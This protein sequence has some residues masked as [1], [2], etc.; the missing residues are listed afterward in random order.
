MAGS[1]RAYDGACS[2]VAVEHAVWDSH[3]AC[4]VAG[5]GFPVTAVDGVV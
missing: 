2:K 4:A 5:C 1:R 3:D